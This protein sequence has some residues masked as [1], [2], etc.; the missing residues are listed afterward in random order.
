MSERA[1]ISGGNNEEGGLENLSPTEEKP[2]K[3]AYANGDWGWG[4]REN[5]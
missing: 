4:N 3:G 1:V 5:Y 2:D